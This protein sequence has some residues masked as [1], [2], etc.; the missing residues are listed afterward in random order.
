MEEA[1]SGSD[2]KERVR[3]DGKP[4]CCHRTHGLVTV[5]DSPGHSQ[6]ILQNPSPLERRRPGH[7]PGWNCRR[8]PSPPLLFLFLR[9]EGPESTAL[10]PLGA[11]SPVEKSPVQLR[12]PWQLARAPE[13]QDATRQPWG[14]VGMYV[15][16]GRVCSRALSQA[17]ACPHSM[18]HLGPPE[19]RKASG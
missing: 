3:L 16:A 18:L 15:R 11:G 4:S 10:L 8:H 2:S 13:E 5:G 17:A 7:F 1:A 6:I 12:C 9:Q 14:N 19:E